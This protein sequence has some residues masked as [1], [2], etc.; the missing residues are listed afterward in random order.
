MWKPGGSTLG[1]IL[2]INPNSSVA[3]TEAMDGCLGIVRSATQ[4]RLACSTL[5]KS[6]PLIE[7]DAHVAEVV[8]H[9]LDEIAARAAAAYVIACFSD[10]GLAQARAATRKPV[11][12]IAEAAYLTALSL[13]RRFGIVSLGPSSIARHLRYLEALRFDTRLAGDRSIDAKLDHFVGRD[14][15]DTVVRV[16]RRLRD[17]D[18]ADV[19]ILGCA[20]LGSYREAVEAE[21]GLAVVDPV[22]A[23]ATLAATMLDLRMTPKAA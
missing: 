1:E 22:Q 17:E 2:I 18:G 14:I 20:G 9:I 11:V 3:M 19:V 12:G 21:L 6:P 10:P 16:G 5:S 13:G 15:V 23:G 4:H 7:S 8:P